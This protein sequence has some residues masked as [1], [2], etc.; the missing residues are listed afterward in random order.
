M[1]AVNLAAPLLIP[2]SAPAAIYMRAPAPDDDGGIQSLLFQRAVQTSC[3]TFRACR[4]SPT[5]QWLAYRADI[6]E[7]LHGVAEKLP[8]ERWHD[9][10]LEMLNAPDEEIVIE[11]VLKKHRGVSA[12]NPY[13][14]PTPMTW[15]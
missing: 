3:Y 2:L 9:F 1:L 11:S 5:A 13:I 14:Q 10:L 4:N 6:S 8:F 12:N 7:N 15:G